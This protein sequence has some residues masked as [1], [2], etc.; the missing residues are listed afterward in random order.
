VPM[1]VPVIT[2]ALLDNLKS[3]HVRLYGFDL[4]PGSRRRSIEIAALALMAVAAARGLSAY[5]RQL[6]VNKL[7]QGFVC[8]LR[9]DLIRR[10]TMMPLEYHC[11]I[12][13]G[14]L[15]DAATADT[16]NLRRFVGQ[17]VVRS[18]TNVLRVVCPVVLLFLHEPLLAAVCCAVI[19]VQWLITHHLQKSAQ[20]ARTQARRT[21]SRFTTRPY[22]ASGPASWRWAARF[23][24]WTSSSGRNCI[25]RIVRPGDQ[26]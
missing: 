1:Q 14:D 26:P 16:A 15:F 12:G 3:K 8:E 7:T 20:R 5:L 9:R 19:P 23:G 22:K 10:L 6:S 25:S 13:A 2:G 11:R 21:R 24:K 18:L 4:S 17:V